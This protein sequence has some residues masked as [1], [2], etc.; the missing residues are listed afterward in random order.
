M[1]IPQEVDLGVRVEDDCGRGEGDLAV[2][3]E[4]LCDVEDSPPRLQLL[5]GEDYLFGQVQEEQGAVLVAGQQV[6]V[7]VAALADAG[8][9]GDVDGVL[10]EVVLD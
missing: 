2:G 9:S 1:T 7:R 10:A 5:L 6:V 8:H 4:R 3:E